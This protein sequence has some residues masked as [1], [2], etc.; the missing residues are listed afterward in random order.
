MFAHII[1]YRDAIG[2]IFAKLIA[3]MFDSAK[4]MVCQRVIQCTHGVAV[5]GKCCSTDIKD[6]FLK[7]GYCC[8][9]EWL[10]K[11][12]NSNSLYSFQNMVKLITFQSPLIFISFIFRIRAGSNL[13]HSH[14][15]ISMYTHEGRFYVQ[16]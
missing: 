14:T 9:A 11:I 4:V 5:K 12:S 10:L 7:F 8:F 2:H 13:E 1:I 6:E 16:V 3:K 15:V